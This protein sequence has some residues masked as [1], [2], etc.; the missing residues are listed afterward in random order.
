MGKLKGKKI[1]LDE[2]VIGKLPDEVLNALSQ[3]KIDVVDIQEWDE[4]RPKF[5]LRAQGNQ[6]DVDIRLK[7]HIPMKKYFLIIS[8]AISLTVLLIKMFYEYEPL[9]RPLLSKLTK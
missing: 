7:L 1:D 6:L 9:I 8:S 4:T 2:L 5:I 3:M